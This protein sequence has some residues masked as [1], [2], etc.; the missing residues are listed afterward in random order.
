MAA[1]FNTQLE[2]READPVR[3]KSEGPQGALGKP[4]TAPG[5]LT[6]PVYELKSPRPLLED[7]LRVTCGAEHWAEIS[8][9]PHLLISKKPGVGITTPTA[10]EETEV[11]DEAKPVIKAEP[12]RPKVLAHVHTRPSAR[13]PL[14][15]GGRHETGPSMAR[16]LL[17]KR[18]TQPEAGSG[19]ASWPVVEVDPPQERNGNAFLH[20]GH[21]APS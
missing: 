14:G 17:N 7:Q 10:A 2:P 4:P 20:F 9:T 13:P 5:P 11:T 21:S 15:P 18:M 8:P 12:A 16:Y 1:M 19:R 3:T 6:G